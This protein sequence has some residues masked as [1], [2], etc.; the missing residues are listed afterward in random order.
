MIK[1]YSFIYTHGFNYS[2]M[3]W[4]IFFFLNPLFLLPFICMKQVVYISI[5]LYF[6][7]LLI[8]CC[9]RMNVMFA[10]AFTWFFPFWAWEW[11]LE[12]QSRFCSPNL[13]GIIYYEKPPII[14]MLRQ[15]FTF[16]LDEVVN[17]QDNETSI[18][19]Q[20]LQILL[21]SLLFSLLSGHGRKRC[22]YVL[23]IL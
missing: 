5:I 14:W 11:T 17:V 20:I 2:Y 10:A 13:H 12:A 4:R 19:K 3:H 9:Y 15:Y 1:P 22:C 6:L 7:R 16:Y 8:I 23:I 18:I 21:N